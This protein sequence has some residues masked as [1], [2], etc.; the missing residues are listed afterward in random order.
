MEDYDFIVQEAKALPVILLLDRSG[1]MS[2]HD[3]IGILNREVNEMI[4]TFS[5]CDDRV[6]AIKVAVYSF[7][8]SGVT[9][10]IPL[11]PASQ[12]P[13]INL[14][15]SGNTPMDQAVKKASDL[16]NDRSK[17]HHFYRPYVILVSD[18]APDHDDLFRRATDEFKAG[19][20]SKKCITMSLAI[21]VTD[22]RAEDN[23]RYFATNEEYFFNI[24][25]V[26]NIAKFFRFV[27]T[28]VVTRVASGTP[29]QLPKPSVIKD[30]IDED[31]D[32][33]W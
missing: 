31:H 32:N 6:A 18:G 26:Q 16:V 1:S 24:S 27:S 5:K 15:A 21:G 19:E 23:L 25:D 28:T 29:A 22:K 14:G 9:E 17:L 10:D 33:I 4:K 30:I 7:G 11:T 3:K 12:M 13:Q 8:G 20:R 2:N